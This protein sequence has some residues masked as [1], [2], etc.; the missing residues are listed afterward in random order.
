VSIGVRGLEVGR[1][2]GEVKEMRKTMMNPLQFADAMN[3][4]SI[5]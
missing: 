4:L 5:L 1:D 3:C 2:E